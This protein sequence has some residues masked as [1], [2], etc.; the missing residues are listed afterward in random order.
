MSNKKQISVEWLVEVM[1]K[2][3]KSFKEFYGSEIE[4]V[5]AMHRNE[6]EMAYI[7]GQQLNSKS[8]TN[9]MIIENAESYYEQTFKK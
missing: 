2:H 8:L 7:N 6:I 4:Q 3:D 5:K 1:L 9:L